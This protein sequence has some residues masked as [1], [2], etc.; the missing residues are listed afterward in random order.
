L[1]IRF[2]LLTARRAGAEDVIDAWPI[3]NRTSDDRE[4]PS[5]KRGIDELHPLLV[6]LVDSRQAGDDLL[7][8][9]GL[10]RVLDDM[11]AVPIVSMQTFDG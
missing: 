9:F 7:C 4:H 2:T 3:G 11:V 1:L 6:R 5:C 10:N 8:L